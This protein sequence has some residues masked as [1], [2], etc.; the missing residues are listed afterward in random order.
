MKH[1]EHLTCTKADGR[2]YS[3]AHIISGLTFYHIAFSYLL[4]HISILS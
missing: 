4:Q 3:T 1:D 2:F